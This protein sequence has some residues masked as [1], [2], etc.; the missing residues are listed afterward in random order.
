LIGDIAEATTVEARPQLPRLTL[1]GAGKLLARSYPAM[2]AGKEL[3]EEAPI[4]C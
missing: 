4:N 1:F 3:D 2:A